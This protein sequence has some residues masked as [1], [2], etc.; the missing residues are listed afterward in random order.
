MEPLGFAA[1]AL[2]EAFHKQRTFAPAA[3]VGLAVRGIQL[4]MEPEAVVAFRLEHPAE[5]ACHSL[6]RSIHALQVVSLTP[7]A[8]AMPRRLDL[9]LV[10][11][12]TGQSCLLMKPC[13][14]GGGVCD[15]SFRNSSHI[16]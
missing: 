13:R 1:L 12:A 2:Q 11:A 7:L 9:L 4:N 15:D 10:L 5:A 6:P 8:D 16:D 3:A 14:S